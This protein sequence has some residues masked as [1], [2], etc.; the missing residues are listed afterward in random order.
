MKCTSRTVLATAC[1]AI[2]GVSL[3]PS[4]AQGGHADSSVPT[5]D[6]QWAPAATAA[7]RVLP[8]LQKP[9][10]EEMTVRWVTENDAHG[11]LT[12]RGPGLRGPLNLASQPS[13]EPL[14]DY[15]D[16]E[17]N[18]NI[19]GLDQGSWLKGDDN[20][21]HTVTIEE[22]L[23]GK[24]YRYDVAQDGAV[25]RGTF[26]TA[27]ESDE[28][29]EVRIVA[30]AD[31]ETEPFGRI[32]KREWEINPISGYADGSA[33]RPGEGSLWADKHGSTTR[34]GEFTLRYPMNQDQAMRENMRWIEE[35]DPDLFLIA[36]DLTQ[37]G[38]YQPA[39][40]EFFGY[41][42]GEH[43]Q[44]AS[45]TPMVTA[46][47]NWETYAAISG[48]YGTPEDRSP[49]VRSRNK[50]HAYFDGF[51]DEA[52]PQ[53]KSS[54]HRVDHGPVTVL[55]IDSTNGVPDEDVRTGTLSNPIFSGDDTNLDPDKLSTDTQGSFLAEEYAAAYPSVFPGSSPAE[56]DL[57][58]FNQGTAQWRW[59]EEQ[60]A[61]ARAAG[62]IVLVQFHHA[63]YSNGVHGTPPNHEYADNQS[64][65]AMRA[66]TPMF[67]QYGVAA[68]ITGHDEMFERSW[69]DSDGDGQGF[70][71]YD[72]GVAADGLRGEQLYQTE[73]GTWAPIRFNTH[74]EW[75]AAIDEPE[76]WVQDEN[77]R[78]QL[79][80]GGLHY[81]H[82][83]IDVA[84]TACGADLT[85]NPVY[86]F[87]IMDDEYNVVDTERRVYDDV[88]TMSVDQDGIATTSSSCKP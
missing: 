8:Y 26:R 56:A 39:W 23:P 47:G 30:F 59:V 3:L 4:V 81:G 73:D 71:S 11:V 51:G 57:P 41:V 36:G 18:Q 28:W 25:F 74:S 7:F 12:V 75:M 15:T 63:A 24:L 64:G 19:P 53:F 52:N 20:Y 32:E 54:Y 40:D 42:A 62:Q 85:M 76:M 45:N 35:A 2:L 34:Y 67:E 66:Y 46:L 9:A 65:V 29:E 83:Q 37:G 88:V 70:H 58:A 6:K 60:L 49:V 78:P 82:L 10:A 55:T 48:G 72:V 1:A 33:M 44:L 38:G 27:P 13:H 80:D 87:P 5:G 21:V 16:A 43:G 79:Q 31:S 84:R 69:V 22:L 50:Y 61:D 14:L 77:G 68:V 86:V 17:R